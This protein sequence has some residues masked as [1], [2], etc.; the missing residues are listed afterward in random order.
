MAIENIKTTAKNILQ[1]VKS[2]MDAQAS[3]DN[4]RITAL[5]S[6]NTMIKEVLKPV[7]DTLTA[8]NSAVSELKAGKADKAT[9][10]AGYGITDA[11]IEGGVITL[12]EN[13]ITPLTA[14]Q[15]L[16]EYAKT[17]EVTQAITNATK[18][19]AD[20][21]T[22]LAGYGITDAKIDAGV[23]TLGNN[24]ITPLT[25]H[26][27]LVEYAKTADV[28]S[29]IN[30]AVESLKNGLVEVVA[31]LPET[32][33]AGKIYLVANGESGTNRYTEYVYTN[34]AFEILGELKLDLT[35]YAKT[36]EVTQAIANAT[37][38]KADKATTLAG[39]GITDAKIADG[40]ITLG[41][42]TITPLTEHQSLADYAKTA[43]V[44]ATYATKATAVT[45]IAIDASNNLSMTINGVTSNVGKVTITDYVLPV[46]KADTLGGVK[47]GSKV[48][49]ASDG[50]LGITNLEASDIPTLTSAKISD[51]NTAVAAVKV[52]AATTADDVSASLSVAE[53]Q[54][55]WDSLS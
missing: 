4:V 15:S 33:E 51:F 27:S 42:Q 45:G 31:V 35:P 39:Y 55:L 34:G 19:K 16:A 29:K 20:K 11:K 36:S 12:G 49:V 3:A 25:E 53:V 38:N 32:G 37:Q 24:T 21:A 26:Q 7:A 6:D 5:E 44:A 1:V 9:T 40:V 17:A 48:T 47:S 28:E 43:D 10:L 46:A 8:T 52:N 18:D 22:T 13:T 14:H 2:K 30:T 41:N 50:T 23:I 54:A